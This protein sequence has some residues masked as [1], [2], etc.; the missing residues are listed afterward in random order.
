MDEAD[1]SV[2]VSSASVTEQLPPMPVKGALFYFELGRPFRPFE[3]LLGVPP[4]SSL[5]C[6]PRALH[7]VAGPNSPLKRLYP[8]ESEVPLDFEGRHKAYEATV[9][10]PQ[11]D[12]E[13][14]L[15]VVEPLIR[16][17][18]RR[19]KMELTTLRSEAPA[20]SAARRSGRDAAEAA[21]RKSAGK[22]RS[23]S[24]PPSSSSSSTDGA[25]E[26]RS[27]GKALDKRVQPP[28]DSSDE[29]RGRTRVKA[30]GVAAAAAAAAGSS[31]KVE[32][33]VE[34][35]TSTASGG[36]SKG[37]A[38]AEAQS[39]GSAKR[40]GGKKSK[41]VDGASVASAAK[42]KVER[43]A[44]ATAT[45]AGGSGG[46]SGAGTGKSKTRRAYAVET[47]TVGGM[48]CGDEGLLRAMM[49][50]VPRLPLLHG[51]VPLLA[52]CTVG[53]AGSLR[54]RQRAADDE[55]KHEQQR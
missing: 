2:A 9:L 50:N 35:K 46:S 53:V 21:K 44:T 27:G 26:R 7:V 34:G 29:R 8:K 37:I 12:E 43:A 15:A 25:A 28:S 47:Q 38:K 14:F 41:A 4:P 42:A 5:H 54:K 36:S 1:E 24:P 17:M 30:P 10:L 31:M 3:Q 40:E 11:L 32:V 19:A 22:A 33:K 39:D 6:V 52:A 51:T 13:A 49:R 55:W 20:D 23:R 16:A 18:E 48:E 45:A